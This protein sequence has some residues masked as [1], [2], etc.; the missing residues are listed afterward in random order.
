MEDLKKHT[1]IELNK[2]GNDIANK[3]EKLKQGILDYTYEIDELE[4]K[5]NK[6]LVLLAELEKNYVG[7]IEELNNK[8]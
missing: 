5:I 4:K 3:H 8:K 7:V 1:P 2:M 6:D